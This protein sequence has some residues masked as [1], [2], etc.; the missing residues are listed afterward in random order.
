V[1]SHHPEPLL[2]GGHFIFTTQSRPASLHRSS[3]TLSYFLP[4]PS[5]PVG[6]SFG[7]PPSWHVQKKKRISVSAVQGLS[8]HCRET[9]HHDACY[10][11][12]SLVDDLIEPDQSNS[13]ELLTLHPDLSPG[14]SVADEKPFA[15]VKAA[16]DFANTLPV[17]E[18]ERCWIRCGDQ[19]QSLEGAKRIVD[20]K[21]SGHTQGP[22]GAMPI[23][24]GRRPV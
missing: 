6:R 1:L 11:N 20:A 16:L 3:H 2:I 23:Q 12:M 9:D 5:R 4:F 19:V 24:S 8:S 22:D 17:E 13:V 7:R 21:R 10:S 18:Q 15:N 14:V